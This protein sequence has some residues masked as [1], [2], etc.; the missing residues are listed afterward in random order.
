MR[1]RRELMLASVSLKENLDTTIVMA[2]GI[3]PL[4]PADG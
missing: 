4:H 3:I 1:K 2:L